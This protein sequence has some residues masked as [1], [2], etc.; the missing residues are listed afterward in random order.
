MNTNK[1]LFK[2]VLISVVTL[3]VVMLSLFGYLAAQEKINI[4]TA[5]AEQLETLPGIGPAKAQDIVKY[6]EENGNF[7]TTEGLKNVSGI[8]DKIFERISDKITVTEE[9]G[10]E[11]PAS[12]EVT[13]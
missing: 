4:N 10:V 8:G 1:K 3:S 13:E 11:A 5:S 6:R 12:E 2:A 7:A 9:A